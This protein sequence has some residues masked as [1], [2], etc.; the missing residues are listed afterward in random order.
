MNL[1]FFSLKSN[2]ASVLSCSRSTARFSPA[3]KII[4]RKSAFALPGFV[5]SLASMPAQVSYVL[6]ESS[7]ATRK[8]TCLR[9]KNKEILTKKE[10]SSNGK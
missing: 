5:N 8:I 6:F 10:E 7:Q 2:F 1:P 3:R 9:S 4:A